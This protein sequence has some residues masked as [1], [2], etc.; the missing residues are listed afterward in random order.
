MRAA[1]KSQELLSQ[2]LV[3]EK[4]RIIKRNRILHTIF[5]EC[6]TFLQFAHDVISCDFILPHNRFLLLMDQFL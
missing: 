4:Q 6:I 5:L 2:D 1:L 3:P